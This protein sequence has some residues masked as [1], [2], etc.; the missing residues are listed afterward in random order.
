MALFSDMH[1]NFDYIES[2]NNQQ[3]LQF[4]FNREDLETE[5]EL[6]RSWKLDVI[7]QIR[8]DILDI[9]DG[10]VF[11]PLKLWPQKIKL[12]FFQKPITDAKLFQLMLFLIG[13]GCPHETIFKWIL[14]SIKWKPDKFKKRAEQLHWIF[15]HL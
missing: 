15:T 11:F 7:V 10:D 9:I 14:T 2:T 13:N 4:Q 5:A 6:Y 1:Y 8:K 3:H 12:A